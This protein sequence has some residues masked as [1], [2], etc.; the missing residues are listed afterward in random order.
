LTFV[1]F[2]AFK[3]ERFIDINALVKKVRESILRT[4]TA[5]KNLFEK[6]IC[7]ICLANIAKIIVINKH[8]R[9]NEL[10]I[11]LYASDILFFAP[12]KLENAG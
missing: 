10:K 12:E 5:S 2:T 7:I 9:I 1:L 11:F 3:K 4:G 8:M 6:I